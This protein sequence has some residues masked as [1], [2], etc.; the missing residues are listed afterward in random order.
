VLRITI[1]GEVQATLHHALRKAGQLECGGVLM[2]EH[3]DVN[4]FTV[5][6]LTVQRTGT[7][8]SFVRGLAEALKA[9]K[10][11]C[12]SA[13]NNF[14]RFN[15]LGEW[16]SHPLFSVQPSHQDHATMLELVTDRRVGANF[17]VLL[18]FRLT[19][20]ALEGSAHTYLPDGSIYPSELDFEEKQ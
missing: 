13:G 3:V 5:R 6:T 12:S 2:G 17:I 11:F 1:P 15:Y 16:H 8:G 9:I 14:T 10:A 19:G 20:E 18:I 7:M 4:H